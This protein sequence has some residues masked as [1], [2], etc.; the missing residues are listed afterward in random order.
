MRAEL[1]ARHRPDVLIIRQQGVPRLRD[2]ETAWRPSSC[3]TRKAAKLYDGCGFKVAVIT[4]DHVQPCQTA[5]TPPT[6]AAACHRRRCHQH[7]ICARWKRW[8]SRRRRIAGRMASWPAAG[9]DRHPVSC[10]SSAAQRG[11]HPQSDRTAPDFWRRREP[12]LDMQVGGPDALAVW[13]DP[14]RPDDPVAGRWSVNA[15]LRAR[16]ACVT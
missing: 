7:A 4:T 3:V 13:F 12:T 16:P 14:A 11:R 8:S 2:G 10:V 15:R 1:R 6:Q 5:T 9:A